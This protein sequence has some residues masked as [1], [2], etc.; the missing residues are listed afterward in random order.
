MAAE[1]N[2]HLCQHL[3]YIAVPLSAYSY[4]AKIGILVTNVAV[5]PELFSLLWSDFGLQCPK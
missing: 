4:S 1:D 2:D 5:F 3:L